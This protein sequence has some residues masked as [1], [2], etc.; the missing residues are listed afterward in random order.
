MATVI[1]APEQF[2]HSMNVNSVA[3]VFLAGA[4]DMGAAVDWQAQVIDALQDKRYVL[5]NPRRSEFNESTLDEQIRWELHHLEKATFIFMW[6]PRDAKAP[7]A[8]FE[9]GLYWHSGHKLI[10]GAE[11]GFYRR[12]NLELTAEFHSRPLYSSLS[13]MLHVPNRRAAIERRM[14]WDF[15]P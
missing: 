3:R 14:Q 6:F 4:I 13:E 7:I 2:N 10:V 15:S 9:S 11:P 5:F 12:R 8:L 1:T